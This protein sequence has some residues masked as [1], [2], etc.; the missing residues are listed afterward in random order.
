MNP[1]HVRATPQAD[2]EGR[3]K[4]MHKVCNHDLPNQ[5][6]VLPSLLKLMDMEEAEHLSAQG[7]EFVRRMQNASTHASSM[8]RFLKEMSGLGTRVARLEPIALAELARE[9]Q[10]ELQHLYPMRGFTFA[11]DW[12]TPKIVGDARIFA[13]ALIEMYSGLTHAGAESCRVSGRSHEA[14]DAT[15]LEFCIA[16]QPVA[17]E[18]SLAAVAGKPR[19]PEDRMQIILA[20]EWFALCGANIGPLSTGGAESRFNVTVVNRK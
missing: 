15:E 10:G 7:R 18:P 19:S 3:L 6:V 16:E 4:L 2:A 1:S 8:V 20:R 17:P 9:L 5:L 14:G 12:Q 13:Q 11:W